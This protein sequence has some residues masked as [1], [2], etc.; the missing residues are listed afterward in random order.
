M[1]ERSNAL[2]SSRSFHIAF[3]IGMLLTMLIY[4]SQF[5]EVDETAVS[6]ISGPTVLSA[7][8]KLP[9]GRHVEKLIGLTSLKTGELLKI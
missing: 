3:Q 2:H 5:T 4:N 6:G 1:A 8:N 9:D 7:V